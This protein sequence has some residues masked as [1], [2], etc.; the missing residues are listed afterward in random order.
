MIYRLAICGMLTCVCSPALAYTTIS[1]SP[2]SCKAWTSARREGPDRAIDREMWVLGFLSGVGSTRAITK[3]D[4]LSGMDKE[5]VW[6][7]I[8]KYC[9]ENPLVPLPDAALKFMGAH[10]GL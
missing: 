3:V 7:W 4:P 6:T 10:P 9:F 5:G 1:P 8:D 2:Q